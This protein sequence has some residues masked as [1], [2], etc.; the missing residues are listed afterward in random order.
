MELQ[1]LIIV[2]A[3][4]VLY[5]TEMDCIAVG[6]FFPR[7]DEVLSLLDDDSSGSILL[8]QPYPVLGMT[9][10]IPLGMPNV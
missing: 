5:S 2:P 4:L 9:V 6:Q 1:H 3:L 8:S 10:D 7:G